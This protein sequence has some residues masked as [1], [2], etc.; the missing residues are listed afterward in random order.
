M[1]AAMT[2]GL[3]SDARKLRRFVNDGH[4][5]AEFHRREENA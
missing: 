5:I 2:E 4:A 1:Y 3:S